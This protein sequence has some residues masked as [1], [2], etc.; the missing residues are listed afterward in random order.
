MKGGYR[1]EI[2]IRPITIEP[3]SC[4]NDSECISNCK[5]YDLCERLNCESDC[6][7]FTEHK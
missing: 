7:F 2:L 1:M 3:Y 6:N 4:D 5:K